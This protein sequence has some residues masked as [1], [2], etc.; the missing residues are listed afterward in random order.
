M[1]FEKL[2]DQLAQSQD[3]ASGELVVN[4]LA[5]QVQRV[6][7]GP[8]RERAGSLSATFAIR[9]KTSA[10]K[11]IPVSGLDNTLGQLGTIVPDAPILLLHFSGT[12]RVFSVFVQE[13][14]GR[15]IGIIA[16]ERDR[17]PPQPS[18]A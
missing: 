13:S 9:K 16:V 2:V 6:L 3:P 11:G 7:P 18:Q 5:G 15:V 4:L 17:E 10:E 14:D 12:K 1:T 8:G